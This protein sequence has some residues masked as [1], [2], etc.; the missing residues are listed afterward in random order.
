MDTDERTYREGMSNALG[1]I[2]FRGGAIRFYE[3]HGGSDTMYGTHYATPQEA[4]PKRSHPV[5]ECVCGGEEAVECYSGY[6]GGFYFKGFAC[7]N[8]RSCRGEYTCVL[9]GE[10]IDREHIGDDW[11]AA[12]MTEPTP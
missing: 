8:C 5:M 3:Y 2:R 10:V 7:M 4:Y 11:F 6:G 1:A 12:V 9:D